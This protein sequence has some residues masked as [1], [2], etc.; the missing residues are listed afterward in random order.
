MTKNVL[1]LSYNGLLETIL[2]SQTIPYLKGLSKSG[3][4]FILLTFEK[5]KDINRIGRLG[6]RSIKNELKNDS[7]IWVWLKYHKYPDKLSTFFD[8]TTGFFTALV[9]M[10]KEKIGII[11]VRGI[12]PAVI[13][14]LLSKLFRCKLIFDS[15]GL[16]AEEFVGGEL[17]REGGIFFKLAKFAEKSLLT[18]SDAVVVLTE[19]HYK[20]VQRLP[21]FKKGV[22][23][24]VIP[25]CV[26][27]ERFK[28]AGS[29]VEYELKRNKAEDSI[30]FVYHGKLGTF[31]MLKEMLHFF[32]LASKKFQNSKFL[33]LTQDDANVLKNEKVRIDSSRVHFL[34]PPFEGIPDFLASANVGLF[35]INAYKKFGSSPIKLGELLASGK[36]VI[37]NSGIGD[38]EELVSRNRVGV[39]IRDFTEREYL[40]K[41]EELST[42]LNEGDKLALRCR[43]TAEKLLSL[44]IGTERYRDIYQ[45]MAK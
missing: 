33:I 8:L 42:L 20:W 28:C 39:V 29:A 5:E 3:F 35:F 7:I 11:H 24:S 40:D 17:W 22:Q 36:P 15:R 19:K 16:L 9:I 27:L 12:T 10:L 32:D 30:L 13:G 44:K 21:Y 2:P 25:C 38:T 37:I 23:M 34:S 6:M 41:I 26:D 31:Y 1:Y 14:L 43:E 45:R 4:R 18:N